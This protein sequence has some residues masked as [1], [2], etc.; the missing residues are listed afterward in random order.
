MINFNK[1]SL[2]YLYLII[3][4]FT[5]CVYQE[6]ISEERILHI[7]TNIKVD[8]TN[9]CIIIGGGSYKL[10]SL[11]NDKFIYKIIFNRVQYSTSKG[12][13]NKDISNPY[14]SERLIFDKCKTDLKTVLK[15]FSYNSIIK[16]DSFKIN[17]LTVYKIPDF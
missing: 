9:M 13:I 14:T 8:S 5:S 15:A 4:L 16:L 3:I 6:K 12:I 7:Q 2:L 10:Y 17:S 11:Y 1:F